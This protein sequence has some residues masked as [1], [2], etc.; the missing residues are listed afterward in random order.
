MKIRYLLIFVILSTLCAAQTNDGSR[1]A[2][3]SV[4]ATG[5]WTKISVDRSGIY[6]L[7]YGDIKAMGITP[8]NVRIYGYGGALLNEDFT[9][10]YIDDLPQVPIYI[11]KGSDGVFGEGDY[12]L[13]YGQAN[14]SWRY[15]AR[16]GTFSHVRNHYSDRG[17]YFVTAGEGE[18]KQIPRQVAE[19]SSAVGNLTYF[20]DYLLHD[21]DLLNMADCGR[22]FYGEEFG[23]QR[24]SYD[25]QFV[26]PNTE[27]AEAKMFVDIA[28]KALNPNSMTISLNGNS[29]KTIALGSL[30]GSSYQVAVAT[31]DTITFTP[32]ATDK[33]D[34]RF[35]RNSP[36][37]QAYLN[38]FEINFRRK[39]IIDGSEFYFRN[40]DHIGENGVYDFVLANASPSA[41]IWE[42]TDITDITSVPVR[43]SQ[44]K[45]RN[46]RQCGRRRQRIQRVL[47][48]YARRL[49]ISQIRQDVLRQGQDR[50]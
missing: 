49:G 46:H 6:R 15:D 18:A 12:I 7:D 40:V 9:A 19:T 30:Y 38:Y 39:L 43:L 25:F 33:F 45:A 50:R 8:E 3:S 21:Q 35:A 17:Y 32:S 37:Y 47:E 16:K 22:E 41:E 14:I 42:I 26:V 1:Y 29:L 2:S 36:L 44:T 28:S 5:Q 23:M 24:N 11:H 10:K 20:T 31:A 48:R 4:L 27:S 34:I 13:F